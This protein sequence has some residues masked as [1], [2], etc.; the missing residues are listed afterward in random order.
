MMDA[1]YTA[2][3]ELDRIK[4]RASDYRSGRACFDCQSAHS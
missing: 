2:P 1:A 3:P 4:Q